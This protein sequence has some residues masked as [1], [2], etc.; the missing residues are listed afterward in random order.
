MFS[1]IQYPSSG[2]QHQASSITADYDLGLRWKGLMLV[3]I[4][5]T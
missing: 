3:S 4:S 2:I 1:S 5:G